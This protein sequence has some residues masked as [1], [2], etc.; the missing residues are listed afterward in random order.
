MPDL[1][2]PSG[3]IHTCSFILPGIDSGNGGQIN[4]RSPACFPPNDLNDVHRPEPARIQ[5]KV[6]WFEAKINQ[7]LVDNPSV[8]RDH[9]IGDGDDNNP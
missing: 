9:N 4:N 6:N 7:Q 5:Q 3:T 2:Q 1:S 8:H